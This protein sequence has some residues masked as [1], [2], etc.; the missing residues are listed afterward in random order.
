M[1]D[2][3]RRVALEGVSSLHVGGDRFDFRR[4]H[5]SVTGCMPDDAHDPF[6]RRLLV[7]HLRKQSWNSNSLCYKSK[8]VMG[9]IHFRCAHLMVWRCYTISVNIKFSYERSMSLKAGH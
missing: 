9:I 2:N 4:C 8:Q 6:R 3:L 7:R 5:S 1:G